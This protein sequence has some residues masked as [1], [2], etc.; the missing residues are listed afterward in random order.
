MTYNVLME[1]SN[2]TH[3]FTTTTTF[4]SQPVSRATYVNRNQII[5]PFWILLQQMM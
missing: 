1:T 3:S 5:K 2:H 4:V